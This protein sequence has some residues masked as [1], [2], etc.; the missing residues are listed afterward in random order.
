MR[1]LGQSPFEQAL[2]ASG[3]VPAA[4]VGEA[5]ELLNGDCNDHRLAAKLV[6]LGLLNEW[7][8]D[9][10]SEGR[11]KFSLGQYA[12]IDTV[13]KGGMGHVFKGEHQLLGR[14]EAI[15]VLPRS[16]SRPE[17]IASF[18]QE[19]RA[20][21]QLNHPNLVR[22][23]YADR[24][25]DT[26]FLVTEFVPGV[27]LRRLVRRTG[28]LP[29]GAAAWVVLQAAQG[30]EYAHRRGIVHRDVKPG[31]LLVTPE[32]EVKLADLGLAWY[33]NREVPTDPG[34]RKKVVGTC[35]YLAPESITDPTRIIPVSDLYSLGCTLYYA[36]T[37][38]V[39]YPGG[40]AVE[41]MR[42]CLREAP[43]PPQSI[44]PD[45][46]DN[47]V[48]VIAR[49]MDKNPETRVPSATAAIDLIRPLVGDGSRAEVAA[50]IRRYEVA[51]AERARSD[52]SGPHAGASLISETLTDSDSHAYHGT[53]DDA[54][55]PAIDAQQTSGALSSGSGAIP[56]LEPA[57]EEPGV[58]SPEAPLPPYPVQ[59]L[60][61]AVWVV[62]GVAVLGVVAIAVAG[63]ASYLG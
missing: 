32:G 56:A 63:L 20:Q 29:T 43:L 45:L 13:A 54:S 30:L 5:R 53:H 52:R 3:L 55:D 18:R 58:P 41:K 15:K 49:L 48:A 44:Q 12:I 42:R 35:D 60:D 8:V 57:G 51:K 21:A 46:P 1:P 34:G 19:I 7:Q 9:Q 24:D 22:V 2:L 27:D 17:A 38:K 25:G 33:L 10:L 16:K 6:E 37:G 23:S 59:P 14:V 26:Y 28:P 11:T 50:G 4:Q 47:V 62:T 61:V 36:V 31:N 39:P 40:N